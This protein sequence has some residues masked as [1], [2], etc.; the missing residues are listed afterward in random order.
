[1]RRTHLSR[2]GTLFL[3]LL[4][5]ACTAV[6]ISPSRM[7][8]TLNPQGPGAARLAELWWVM[9][10]AGTL[11]YLLVLALLFAVLLRRLRA[12]S[13]TPPE[14]PHGGDTGRSWVVWGGIETPIAYADGTIYA[15][16]T[17]LPSPYNATAYDADTPEQALNRSEGGTVYDN[18]TAEMDAIDAATG[19]I[20]WRYE[21]DRIAF[22]G[23]T[24]VNDLVVT[25]TLDG[26]IYALSREDGSVVWQR[27]A[28]GGTNAW[29]AVSGDTIVWPFGI[30]DNPSV[31]AL[32]LKGGG[33]IPTPEPLRTSVQTPQGN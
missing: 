21:F 6:S 18:G 28:P 7:P 4:T 29:P 10:V 13:L 14:E 30:G 2:Y 11:P 26:M 25:A 15:L 32:S 22:G 19:E 5:T 27:Q 9:L 31:I 1:M 20:L 17:N 24:V 16:T 12:T 33:S 8:S 3:L 23:A